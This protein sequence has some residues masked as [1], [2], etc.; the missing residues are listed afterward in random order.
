LPVDE[1]FSLAIKRENT[2]ARE[3]EKPENCEHHSRGQNPE[4][5]KLLPEKATISL[6]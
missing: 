3:T 4:G 6:E 1:N 5:K 2:A